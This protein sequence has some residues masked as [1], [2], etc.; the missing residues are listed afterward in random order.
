MVV[1][2]QR[3]FRSES[4]NNPVAAYLPAVLLQVYATAP[5]LESIAGAGVGVSAHKSG[6]EQTCCNLRAEQF[7]VRYPVSSLVCAAAAF[8]GGAVDHDPAFPTALM[9]HREVV[10]KMFTTPVNAIH[11]QSASSYPSFCRRRQANNE[12]STISIVRYPTATTY[13]DK[14]GP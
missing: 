13:P 12:I 9:F 7:T 8:R 3:H 4:R 11:G 2:G 6:R 14:N 10:K 1:C 5:S